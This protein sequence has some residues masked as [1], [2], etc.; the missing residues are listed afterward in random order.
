MQKLKMAFHCQFLWMEAFFKTKQKTTL[1]KC[2]RQNIDQPLL[3]VLYHWC[4]KES[5]SM[6][7]SCLQNAR[8]TKTAVSCWLITGFR[9][10]K[11]GGI[12]CME[13]WSSGWGTS[14]DIFFLVAL[15]FFYGFLS[16]F[17]HSWVSSHALLILGSPVTFCSFLSLQT[18][19]THS[20]VS[21]H[22]LLILESL[23]TFYSFFDLQSPFA[24]SWVSS[25]LLLILGSPVTF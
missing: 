19:F 18:L 25:H 14:S 8:L 21:S 5:P 20:W 3:I 12:F 2:S 4:V 9:N 1:K 15:F 22:L 6:T 11:P 13:L 7:S 24:H 16:P 10:D 23:V 17:I